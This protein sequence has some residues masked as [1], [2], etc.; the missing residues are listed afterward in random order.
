MAALVPTVRLTAP[1]LRER[2]NGFSPVERSRI[3]T[4]LVADGQKTVHDTTKTVRLNGLLATIITAA[5]AIPTDATFTI[6]LINEDGIIE[7]TSGAIADAGNVATNVS[8]TGAYF[9]G[10]YTVQI[11]FTTVL[12]GNTAEFDVQFLNA[13]T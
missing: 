3:M 10:N 13:T 4:P 2:E 7:Y 11:D 8:T 12:S 9:C 1:A 6:S 5:P